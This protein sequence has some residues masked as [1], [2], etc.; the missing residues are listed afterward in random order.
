MLGCE[1]FY[2][3][4]RELFSGKGLF[5][6]VGERVWRNPIF[7][8]RGKIDEVFEKLRDNSDVAE[9]INDCDKIIE[10]KPTL[11]KVVI[12]SAMAVKM[13]LCY[14]SGRYEEIQNQYDDFIQT[15]NDADT[16]C[17][18]LPMNL[19]SQLNFDYSK[20]YNLAAHLAEKL[21]PVSE[22]EKDVD[23]KNMSVPEVLT[24]AS[25]VTA[26]TACKAE[27]IR[28]IFNKLWKVKLLQPLLTIAAYGAQGYDCNG[29][30]DPER[31]LKIIFNDGFARESQGGIVDSGMHFANIVT[32]S[33]SGKVHGLDFNL[34]NSSIAGTIVHE[35]HHYFEGLRFQNDD[36]PYSK[37][38]DSKF[39]VIRRLA[40]AAPFGQARDRKTRLDQMIKETKSVK[41]EGSTEFN[42]AITKDRTKFISRKQPHHIFQSVKNYLSRDE[43]RKEILVRCSEAFGMMSDELGEDEIEN[44]LKKSG[45]EKCVGFFQEEVQEMRQIV[46]NLQEIVKMSEETDEEKVAEL[47]VPHN[48]K[49]LKMRGA[50]ES[51]IIPLKKVSSG[52]NS[53]YL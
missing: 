11:S 22:V 50:H 37:V 9:I 23:L 8:G 21:Q 47:K 44:T 38:L 19:G 26:L 17:R 30:Y 46:S 32:I 33:L 45:L 5:C 7:S 6:F 1:K 42:F 25:R 41:S 15:V 31:K 12:A 20:F 3:F 14:E 34:E 49:S 2:P 16:A 4:S 29:N 27:D 13:Q 48:Q 35:L 10:S 18:K 24:Q 36:L 51:R 28:N 53:I 43:R 40:E 52:E 39:P